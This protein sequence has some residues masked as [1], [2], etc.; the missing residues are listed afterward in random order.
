MAHLLTGFLE[1]WP[2]GCWSPND[3]VRRQL[4]GAAHDVEPTPARESLGT[5]AAEAQWESIAPQ[6]TERQSCKQ[7]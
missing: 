2:P 5:V 6:S 7:A 3:V 1:P 4:R